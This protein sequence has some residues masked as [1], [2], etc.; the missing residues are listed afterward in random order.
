V[1]DPAHVRV[2]DR[3]RDLDHDVE[4]L[5]AGELGPLLREGLPVDEVHREVE[6]PVDFTYV[7]NGDDVRMLELGR[8]LGLAEE[9]LLLPLARE[10]PREEDLQGDDPVQVALPRLVDGPHAAAGDLLQDLV[11]PVVEEL[12]VALALV[13]ALEETRAPRAEDGPRGRALADRL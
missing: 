9:A 3:V 8:R 13:P 12:G 2:R 6:V 11:A 4:E 5:L 1:N 7:I 10:V